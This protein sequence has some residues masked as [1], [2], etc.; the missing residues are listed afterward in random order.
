MGLTPPFMSRGR[1]YFF[2]FFPLFTTIFLSPNEAKNCWFFDFFSLFFTQCSKL[3]GKSQEKYGKFS[4]VG[5]FAP[6]VV[7]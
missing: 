6:K 7:L 1:K 4:K 2:A 5:N 3:A